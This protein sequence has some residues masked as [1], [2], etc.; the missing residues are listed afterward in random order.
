MKIAHI[1]VWTV[2]LERLK[3]FYVK[4]FSAVP[5][6][7]Y[8]RPDGSFASYFLTFPGGGQL[9]IMQTPDVAPR[10]YDRDD[11]VIGLTHLAIGVAS[12]DVVDIMF[13][14]VQKAG[15]QIE[16][17]PRQTGDGYYECAIFDP[18]GNI[19]EIVADG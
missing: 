6:Q 9:E 1:A 17:A 7:K 16:K 3:D 4:Y 15:C 10:P 12:R 14:K 13:A 11:R 19:I 18:D 5:N 2:Q 8:E